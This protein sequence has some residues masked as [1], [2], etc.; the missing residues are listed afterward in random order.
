VYATCSILNAEGDDI[1]RGFLQRTPDARL[2]AMQLPVGLASRCGI[3]IAPGGDFDG[4]YY[5]RLTRR[6]NPAPGGVG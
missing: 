3:R 2:S 5:A 4:F 1:L 6:G